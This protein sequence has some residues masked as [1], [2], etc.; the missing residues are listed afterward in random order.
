[1]ALGVERARALLARRPRR[2]VGVRCRVHRRQRHAALGDRLERWP[3]AQR[4][5]E[6]LSLFSRTCSSVL[7]NSASLRE[8][9]ALS[10]VKRQPNLRAQE[11]VKASEEPQSQPSHAPLAV[12]CH[13]TLSQ[14]LRS[15]A[16][17]S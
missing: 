11:G 13:L 9:P 4:E 6:G 10:A 17:D 2:L 16:L 14:L 1:C 8:A 5:D 3:F 7:T 12:R 15:P